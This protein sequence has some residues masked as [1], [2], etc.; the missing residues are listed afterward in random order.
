ML[1]S[2]S[3]FGKL[4]NVLTCPCFFSSGSSSRARGSSSVSSSSS[5]AR[6]PSQAVPRAAPAASA[7]ARCRLETVAV[8][9]EVRAECGGCHLV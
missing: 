2:L 6:A 7:S 3:L 5:G 1:C 4:L 9:R 8:L